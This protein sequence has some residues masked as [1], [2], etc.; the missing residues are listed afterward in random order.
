MQVFLKKRIEVAFRTDVFRN[1]VEIFTGL[2]NA[3]ELFVEQFSTVTVTVRSC[4]VIIF[5]LAQT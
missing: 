5:V 3:L 2:I 4:M 1:R